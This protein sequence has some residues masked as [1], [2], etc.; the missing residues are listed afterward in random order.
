MD[1]PALSIVLPCLDE[2]PTIARALAALQPLRKLGAEV[3]V[4][5]GGSE[6]GTPE[7]CHAGCDHLLHAPRGRARQMNAGAARASAASLLFLHAD[8]QLPASALD[9]IV[10]GLVDHCWG[11]FDVDIVGNSR[12]LPVVS[13]TMNLRSRITGVATGDQAIF[14]RRREFEK[15][16]G[17]PEQALMEDVEFSIRMRRIQRPCCLRDKVRTSGRRWD[18]HGSIR[19]ILL[20]WRLRLAYALGADPEALSR[21]YRNIRQPR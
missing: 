9:L 4:V 14:V 1:E 13:A 3:I 16:G 18:S 8:T 7:R 21:H 20:M 19:T 12:W 17:F 2:A 6:D 11:R 5:D 10:G 15:I